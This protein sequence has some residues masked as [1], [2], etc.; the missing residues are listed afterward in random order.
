MLHHGCQ[1]RP[2]QWLRTD[3]RG[4]VAEVHAPLLRR[5]RLSGDLVEGLAVPARDQVLD[6][7][8][9]VVLLPASEPAGRMLRRLRQQ[10]ASLDEDGV[11]I[12]DLAVVDGRAVAFLLADSPPSAVETLAREAHA[13]P[14]RA[15]DLLPTAAAAPATSRP[16]PAR[17]PAV[18]AL[19]TTSTTRSAGP[20]ASE[21]GWGRGVVSAVAGAALV[22]GL[23]TVL[24][25][26]DRTRSASSAV[27]PSPAVSAPDVT[28]PPAAAATPTAGPTPGTGIS[29]SSAR[30]TPDE[31]VVL[32]LARVRDDPGVGVAGPR[33]LRLLRGLDA[34]HGA[35]R[36]ALAT[37]TLQFADEQVQAGGLRP[38]VGARIT[39]TLRRVLADAEVPPA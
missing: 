17:P 37:R 11:R 10:V 18:S 3:L 28:A 4:N 22:L 16:P 1:A 30:T 8:V 31:E 21:R 29:G 7:M 34:E 2:V 36:A 9:D 19:P 13:R 27:D 20:V 39:D 38:D 23:V 25:A 32:L 12:L 6:R 14:E 35:A 33:L 5:Y 26:A 15:E 24:D